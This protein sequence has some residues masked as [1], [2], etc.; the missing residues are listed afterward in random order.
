MVLGCPREVVVIRSQ[1]DVPAADAE[2]RGRV[3][4]GQLDGAEAFSVA[5]S[6]RARRSR[7]RE[8]RHLIVL[9]MN[10][11]FVEE[12]EYAAELAQAKRVSELAVIDAWR[13]REY[14]RA[15]ELTQA[16]FEVLLS[17]QPPGVRYHK[18]WSLHQLGLFRM[19]EG[20]LAGGLDNTFLAF[21]EDAMSGAVNSPERFGELD[22]PA[23]HNLVYV[24]GVPGPALADAAWKV[25]RLVDEGGALEDPHSVLSIRAIARVLELAPA[26]TGQRIPGVFDSTMDE[27]VWIGGS[28]AEGRL[29]NVLRP[30]ADVVRSLSLDPIIAADFS[31]P[32]GM[33]IDEHAIMLELSCRQAIFDITVGRGQTDEITA[34]PDT[35]RSRTLAVY[36]ATHLKAPDVSRG[37]TLSKLERWEVPQLPFA[38][39]DELR[40]IVA[41][42]LRGVTG[43]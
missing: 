20:D 42:W 8:W 19:F 6:W 37:M 10:V 9:H 23:A 2:N 18:G 3:A 21:T 26:R 25:R 5:W 35:M 24:Y 40:E 39:V 34:L 16:A 4:I 41:T 36:D 30:I 31:I 43:R 12:H 27:R 38:S 28:Y 14:P 1:P 29:E 13:R 11:R 33:G 22:A 17:A 15:A 32:A 7:R